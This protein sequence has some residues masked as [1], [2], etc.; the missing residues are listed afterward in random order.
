MKQFSAPHSIFEPFH[1]DG[2]RSI[3]VTGCM[4]S[5]KY[6]Q[7]L[8]RPFFRLSRRHAAKLWLHQH[9]VTSTVHVRR[10][11]KIWSE[12]LTVPV[13]FYEKAMSML[14]TSRIAVCMDISSWV[15]RQHV[16]RNAVI[17]IHNEP[18]FDIALLAEATDTVIIAAG[19]SG[20]WG[21]YLS[22][23][24][25]NYFYPTMY[26]GSLAIDYRE[27]DYIPYNAPG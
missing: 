22:K 18:W 7:H 27:A 17:S 16:F 10:G 13:Q 19:T 21:A 6:F 5:F 14:N 25:H 1:F 11:D 15:R 20:W 24:K 4:Q 2:R 8:Q 9:G 23:A 3:V 12:S 26:V